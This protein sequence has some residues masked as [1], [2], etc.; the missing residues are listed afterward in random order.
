MYPIVQPPVAVPSEASAATVTRPPARASTDG[1]EGQLC[2]PDS[3]RC[4]GMIAQRALYP[5]HGS[6]LQHARAPPSLTEKVDV[7]VAH[8]MASMSGPDALNTIDNHKSVPTTTV[9]PPSG[10]TAQGVLAMPSAV[11]ASD[12]CAPEPTSASSS[13]GDSRAVVSVPRQIT[14]V[15]ADGVQQAG[16]TE[17]ANS[18][19]APPTGGSLVREPET[20]GRPAAEPVSVDSDSALSQDLT[21]SSTAES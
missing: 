21:L 16:K 8:E 12:L 3:N 10:D 1:V 18:R 15:S 5:E 6:Y 2:G 20:R 7:E 17:V 9:V 4:G 11:S 14:R 13:T 19:V